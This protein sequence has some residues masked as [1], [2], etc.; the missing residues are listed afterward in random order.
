MEGK[1]PAAE[2]ERSIDEN[3]KRG[4]NKTTVHSSLTWM[5]LGEQPQQQ[6]HKKNNNHITIFGTLV[7]IQLT[8]FK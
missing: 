3:G 6:G 7:H 5:Y 4:T 2:K 8:N 1:R